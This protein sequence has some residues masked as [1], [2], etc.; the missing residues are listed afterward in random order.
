[1]KTKQDMIDGIY[2]E[3]AN[4]ELNHN[5]IT[6]L[7][8]IIKVDNDCNCYSDLYIKEIKQELILENKTKNINKPVMIWDV[9]DWNIHT[10]SLL[11]LGRWYNKRLPI[12]S[13]SEDCIKYI[14][15]LIK[16]ENR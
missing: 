8:T 13:Q 2:K 4:K 16:D 14:Y 12:E 5:R 11:I 9:L 7:E 1:M 10:P 15:N 3:I 6:E